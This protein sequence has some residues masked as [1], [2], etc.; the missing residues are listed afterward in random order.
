M[1]AAARPGPSDARV[2]CPQCGG[3]VHPIA[4]RCKHCKADLAAYR[5]AR[6]AA[7]A[8]LPPLAQLP[9]SPPPVV[10]PGHAAYMPVPAGA[11]ATRAPRTRSDDDSQPIL[12]P[13]PTAR[14]Q[15]AAP[16]RSLLAHWPV[17][18]IVLAVVAIAVAVA[19]MLWPAKDKGDPKTSAPM[20]APE[21]MDTN[22]LAPQGSLTPPPP[23]HP[24][25]PA[26]PDPPAADP[27]ANGNGAAPAAPDP[28]LDPA[29]PLHDPFAA[30]GGAPAAQFSMT[31]LK[32]ACDRLATCGN[33]D[34]MLR[35]TCDGFSHILPNAPAPTCAAAQRCLARVDALDCDAAAD[36]TS[37]TS[38]MMDIKECLDAA[39][40]C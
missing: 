40:S 22:P 15:G 32:H 19:L 9:A 28:N 38:V 12:P 23:S 30:Q 17:I 5:S 4:G 10:V 39:W 13:R 21:R 11:V 35:A 8:A 1:A 7:Q 34:P 27:W 26:P 18:V 20:P 36:M 2:P 33:S 37:P 3:L 6:P 25:Q 29:D 31:I 16:K 14:M 24:Q